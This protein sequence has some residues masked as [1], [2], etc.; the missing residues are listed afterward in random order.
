MMMG[1]YFQPISNSF[2]R[3]MYTFLAATRQW[4]QNPN[5]EKLTLISYSTIDIEY[6]WSPN[7]LVAD[8]GMVS[9]IIPRC[10]SIFQN[11]TC[12]FPL[13]PRPLAPPHPACTATRRPLTLSPRPCLCTVALERT[14]PTVTCI[15]STL[16]PGPGS[17]SLWV[18]GSNRDIDVEQWFSNG[19]TRTPRGT[20]E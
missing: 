20:L 17:W 19:G 3:I 4:F 9:Y 2:Y 11:T 1:L 8:A 16:R 12:G 10:V 5:D 7:E 13:T 15:F 14:K 18:W 6:I